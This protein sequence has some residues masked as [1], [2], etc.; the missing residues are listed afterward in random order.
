MSDRI[1]R[2]LPYLVG[3]A[4]V[5]MFVVV[6]IIAFQFAETSSRRQA[7]VDALSADVVALR[8]QVAATG[9]EPVAPEPDERVD[10]VGVQ[11]GPTGADGP[12]GPQG[13]PG[14]PGEPGAVGKTGAAG[15]V[16]P[17][18]PQGPPGPPG[19]PGA[20]GETGATGPAGQDGTDGAQGPAGPPG[21]D[22]APGPQG[23]AGPPGPMCPDGYV[24]VT[25]DVV[26]EDPET[27]LTETEPAAL[28]VVA[29]E[30]GGES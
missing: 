8:D 15:P 14:P 6:V 19:E 17:A 28:C 23:P 4:F 22:G 11:P 16:G 1:F 18:G 5:G 10:D 7:A 24:V 26:V 21:T 29:P 13:P 27:G 12:R 20:D 30:E 9:Q 25:R 2:A 3:M